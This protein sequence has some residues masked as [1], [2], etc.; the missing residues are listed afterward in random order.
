MSKRLGWNI[1][2]GSDLA[3][4]GLSVDDNSGVTGTSILGEGKWKRLWIL[5]AG[6]NPDRNDNGG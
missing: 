3:Y 4:S 6:P 5:G 1:A 2:V